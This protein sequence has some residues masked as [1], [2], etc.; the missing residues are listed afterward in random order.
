MFQIKIHSKSHRLRSP[1]CGQIFYSMPMNSVACKRLVSRLLTTIKSR[2][3]AFD[4][5]NRNKERPRKFP[6]AMRRC[7]RMSEIHSHSGI[8]YPLRKC[9]RNL[10]TFVQ[11]AYAEDE[12][13]W[14]KFRATLM[15]RYTL[16]SWR[17][18]RLCRNFI[19][20]VLWSGTF[21]WSHG[22]E[23]KMSTNPQGKVKVIK[24]SLRQCIIQGKCICDGQWMRPRT[25]WSKGSSMESSAET[26]CT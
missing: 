5:G 25:S 18:D 2:I 4:S 26:A 10:W 7:L 17:C 24:P 19:F 22:T 8:R 14:S 20:L 6:K 11:V 23:V 3:I 13:L 9:F 15:V 12:W 1:D 21:W 16:R